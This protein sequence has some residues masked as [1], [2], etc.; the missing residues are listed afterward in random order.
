MRSIRI[1]HV[2]RSLRPESGGPMEGI[3]R[4]AQIAKQQSYELEAV[5]LDSPG[6]DFLESLPF[7]VHPLGPAL[8]KYGYT[9]QLVP[10]ME[11]NAAHYDGIVINGLWQY[12]GIGTWKAICKRV[13]YVVFTHGMLDPYFKRRYPFKHLKKWLYWLPFEFRLLRDA[14]AV[15][16][17][18]QL[19]RDLAESSFWLHKWN[20]VVVPYGTTGP[21]F[22]VQESR[23]AFQAR[24]PELTGKRFLLYLSRID[25][26]KGC[27]LLIHSF[28]KYSGKHPDML[29]VIAGPD[30]GNWMPK[31]KAL[32]EQ[33]GVQDRIV[34]PGMLKDAVKWGAFYESEV[35][36]LP[37]H[38]ENFGIAVAEAM[39]CGKPVLT[40]NQVNIWPDIV[41]TASG[42]VEPDTQQGIDNLLRRWFET[43]QEEREFMG[44]RALQL[45]GERFNMRRT[46]ASILEQLGF[47][48]T[49]LA[50]D[51]TA[52]MVKDA[53]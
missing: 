6:D 32:A 28:A 52:T 3:R 26:K 27:D 21:D 53:L 15:L 24:F 10:W 1:L 20:P 19:E 50:T 51:D 2:I 39:A 7:P 8:G 36:I 45:F 47:R 17:T 35:Y 46:A 13:P 42:L 9:R 37:S 31:L 14:N 4:L 5:C 30:L 49:G 43:P 44:Q 40:T 33:L 25:P 16:F 48:Y 23:E 34:W 29:L 41:E 38:Q 11:D 18:S 12:H 22:G